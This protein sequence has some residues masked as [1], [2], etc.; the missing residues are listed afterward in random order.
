MEETRKEIVDLLKGKAALK[1][2]VAEYAESVFDKF[3]EQALKEVAGLR[4]EITDARIRLRVNDKGENE[5]MLFVGSDVLVF[6]LHRNI[7]RLS[8]DNSL[9]NSPYLVKNEDNGFFAII[10][11][12]NFLA[13]SYEQSRPNDIG[14]LVGRVM[15]NHEKHFMVEGE[16]QLGFLY[17]D[18]EENNLTD[19][20]IQHIIQVAIKF[21]IEFDLI[22][23]PYGMIQQVSLY[24]ILAISEDLREATGKRLGFRSKKDNE[25]VL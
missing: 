12:Y 11:I 17:R 7:F 1:Q 15:M 24:Q 13:E 2:N 19:E 4:E 18:L 10:N 25:D 8:D 21:S 3:K 20:I 6:Q 16:G 9:W 23:P 14:Y 22:T 5:F